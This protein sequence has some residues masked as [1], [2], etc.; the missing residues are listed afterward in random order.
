MMKYPVAVGVM[1]A[2]LFL[3]GNVWSEVDV[4]TATAEELIKELHNVGASKAAAIIKYREDNGDFKSVD[5]LE[6]VR[7]IGRAIIEINRDI[8]TVDSKDGRSGLK[9]DDDKASP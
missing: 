4:N 1:L 3:T 5:D 2:A 9:L 6:K 8:L 7:G